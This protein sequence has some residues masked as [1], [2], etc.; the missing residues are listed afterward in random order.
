MHYFQD[1]LNSELT[2][3]NDTNSQNIDDNEYSINRTINKYQS[4]SKKNKKNV[5]NSKSLENLLSINEIT[6]SDK[7]YQKETKKKFSI[8]NFLKTN[9][10]NLKEDLIYYFSSPESLSHFKSNSEEEIKYEFYNNL[11]CQNFIA[12]NSKFK[13]SNENK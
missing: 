12:F 5:N 2:P 8:Y 3:S 13:Y 6:K 4:I 7:E 10:N 1:N 11:H 9:L